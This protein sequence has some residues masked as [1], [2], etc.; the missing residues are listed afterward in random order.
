MGLVTG[1]SAARPDAL[2][3]VDTHGLTPV[4]I[5]NENLY[6]INH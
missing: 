1:R 4:G 6:F 5:Y 2:L 3:T